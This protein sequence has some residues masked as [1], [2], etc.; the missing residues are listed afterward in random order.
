MKETRLG[1][2]VSDSE[3][4]RGRDAVHVA[5]LPVIAGETLLPGYPV[6]LGEDDKAY[7]P[8]GKGESLGIV[9]PFLQSFIQE[10][11]RF[12]LCLY[13]GTVSGM[14]HYWQHPAFTA[15]P[16]AEPAS[17]VTVRPADRARSEQWLRDFSDRWGMPFGVMIDNADDPDHDDVIVAYG[18]DLHTFSELGEDGMLFWHHLQIFKGREYSAEHRDKIVWSCSC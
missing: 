12:W 6:K 17:L 1:E 11:E 8:R 13:P 2:R 5:I 4:E 18:H 10:G 7:I 3:W 14:R 16:A 9:D 15:G